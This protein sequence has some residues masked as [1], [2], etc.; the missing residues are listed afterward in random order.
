MA[1]HL[2]VYSIL[3][4]KML[5]FPEVRLWNSI[6]EQIYGFWMKLDSDRTRNWNLL[7]WSCVCLY[8]NGLTRSWRRTVNVDGLMNA[9]HMNDLWQNVSN[10]GK[11]SCTLPPKEVNW[12]FSR[13]WMEHSPREDVS[14]TMTWKFHLRFLLYK[15]FCSIWTCSR[16]IRVYSHISPLRLWRFCTEKCLTVNKFTFTVIFCFFLDCFKGVSS[17]RLP[18]VIV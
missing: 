15:W 8:C 2:I 6:R 9:N 5:F 13:W 7:R 17:S 14:T 16:F 11:A 12:M 1:N 3:S 4:F 10:T 18:H